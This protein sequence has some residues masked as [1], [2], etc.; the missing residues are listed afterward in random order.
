MGTELVSSFT[1][2]DLAIH[3]SPSPVPPI[4]HG[5]TRLFE[6]LFGSGSPGVS[7]THNMNIWL[8]IF[9]HLLIVYRTMQLLPCI[10]NS[11]V[12][13]EIHCVFSNFSY[14]NRI[15]SAL[16]AFQAKELRVM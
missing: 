10:L 9:E 6:I 5:L 11:Y 13:V 3:L 7:Q 2:L 4:S 15:H 1:D 14:F 16:H 8:R 12:A